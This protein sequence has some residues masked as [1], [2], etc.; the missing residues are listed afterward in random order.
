MSAPLTLRALARYALAGLPLGFVGLPLYVH[1][2]KFYAD[3]LPLSLAYIGFALFAARI[4]DCFLDPFIG[5]WADTSRGSRRKRMV[6]SYVTL[7]AGIIILF[8]LPE[9]STEQNALILLCLALIFTY[10]S[11]SVVMIHYYAAGLSLSRDYHQNTRISAWREGAIL[12]G[13]LI[14]SVVPIWLSN[15]LGDSKLGYLY[16][17]WIFAFLVGAILF[18]LPRESKSKASKVDFSWRILFQ[19]QQMRWTF[20][21]FFL[22]AL[23]TSICATLFLFFVDDI[24]RVPDYGGFFLLIYFFAAI[25]AMPLWTWL[26]RRYGKRRM[27]MAAM[28]LVI[29]TFAWNIVLSA[30]D[31]FFFFII[32]LVSGIGLGGDLALLPSLLADALQKHKRQ[33]G[34]E[35]G[36]W[37]FISKFNLAMAA[38]ISLPLLAYFG[39]VPGTEN[40]GLHALRFSYAVL[41]CLFKIISLFILFISPL[42]NPRRSS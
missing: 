25:A 21:L 3:H 22:N 4:I 41:P 24:I 27:L 1:L 16:F 42:D 40:E 15:Q 28:L 32:C 12:V 17:A 23:P 9:W 5:Y 19:S 7:A 20:A 33:G 38:G 34:L 13:V 18:L 2:P 35:F 36:I 10:I 6:T 31:V 39:Y 37:N 14:A 11:Y 29:V 26:S 8:Y 30:G